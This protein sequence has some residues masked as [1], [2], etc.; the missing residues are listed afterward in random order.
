[1]KKILY[2]FHEL[3]QSQREYLEMICI[4]EMDIQSWYAVT[5]STVLGEEI[6]LTTQ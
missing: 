4:E 2:Q 3:S 5:R 1:M 6:F